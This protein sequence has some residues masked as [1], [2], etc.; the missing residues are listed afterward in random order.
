VRLAGPAGA[1]SRR[2]DLRGWAGPAGAI[3]L[4]VGALAGSGCENNIERSAQLAKQR[5]AVAH[6]TGLTVTRLNPDV[7]VVSTLTLHDENGTAA[8]VTLRNTS[9]RAL[10]EVPI[11][12]A[13]RSARGASLY[14]NAAPGLS[15]ALVSAPLLEPHR[16]FTWIDDQVQ[17]AGGSAASV[18]ARIG[19]APAVSGQIPQLSVTGVHLVEG[20]SNGLAGAGVVVNHSGVAQQELVV[21]A[22]ARRGGR[23][24][25]AG[26]AVLP[27]APAHSSTPF[28]VFFVGS[29][30]GA[31]LAVSAPPTTLG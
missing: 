20:S 23:V 21:Y 16:E 22:V 5:P 15:A 28:E 10:R 25:A 4:A 7:Q 8:V 30:R 14:T 2:R 17:L 1:R 13:V 9:A 27:Q 6:Q 11:A 24:V 31:A 12:I 19:L 26:R 18:S 29:P 3:I